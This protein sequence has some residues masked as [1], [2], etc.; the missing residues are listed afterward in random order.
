MSRATY[1]IMSASEFI[2]EDPEHLKRSPSIY[3]D[4]DG[5]WRIPDFSAVLEKVN[6]NLEVTAALNGKG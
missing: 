4:V 3:L 2:K 6:A 5:K 1:G